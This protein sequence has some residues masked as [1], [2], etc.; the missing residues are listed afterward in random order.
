[1]GG[2][3]V[4]SVHVA[5]DEVTTGKT[6]ASSMFTTLAINASPKPGACTRSFQTES[7]EK[8]PVQLAN[9]SCTHDGDPKLMA[10]R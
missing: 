6:A 8:T 2:G 7:L 3:S 9:D 4:V 5:F 10:A 1:M